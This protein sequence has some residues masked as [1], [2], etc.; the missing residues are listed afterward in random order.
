MLLRT[1]LMMLAAL[2]LTVAINWRMP[3]KRAARCSSFCKRLPYTFS[4]YVSFQMVSPGF[5][6]DV[7]GL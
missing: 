4:P 6:A 3:R 1:A 5:S 2:L 7:A